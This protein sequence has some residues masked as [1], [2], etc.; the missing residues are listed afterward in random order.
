M[1]KLANGGGQASFDSD[2]WW[3]WN[4]ADGDMGRHAA[5]LEPMTGQTAQD[6]TPPQSRLKAAGTYRDIG[7]CLGE[8]SEDDVTIL[9]L[10]HAPVPRAFAPRF[11]KLGDLTHVV[12]ALA[13][14][15]EWV[16]VRLEAK[17]PAAQREELAKRVAEAKAKVEK[18]VSRYRKEAA[19]WEKMKGQAAKSKIHQRVR[20]VMG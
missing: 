2:L 6:N 16:L 3:Y 5:S 12:V 18:A 20:K 4:E 14:S 8:L 7:V 11:A 13:P 19:K 9:R 10:A 17:A 15:P 1:S